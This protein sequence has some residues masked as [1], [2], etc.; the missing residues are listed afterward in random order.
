MNYVNG[1]RVAACAA[2]MALLVAAGVP[3]AFAQSTTEGAIGGVVL[4]VQQASVPGATVSVRNVGTN[5]TSEAVTDPNGRFLVI[6]LQPGVY[7][8]EVMLSGFAPYKR[9][10]V[11]VE[12]GR[13]TNLDVT[14]GVAGQ[15]ESIQ[16]TATTPVIN[17]EQSDFSTNINQTSIA[18]LPTNTRR[19]STFA[20]STPGAAPDG[21]F[22]LV[23]LSRYFRPSEQQLR[24]WRRQHAGLLRGRARPNAVGVL[25]EHGRDPGVPGHHVELFGRIRA[26]R[27]RRGQ[28]RDEKR[29]Q[30]FPRLGVLFHS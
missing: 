3:S 20:L 2:W 9:D 12:V 23:T 11:I 25:R 24:R 30:Q 13:S 22:G 29:Q 28:C 17:M 7:S 26:S 14:L 1:A 5:S 27:R 15:V 19:W 8:V 4:D 16:V 6:R 21:S 18:N 10:N